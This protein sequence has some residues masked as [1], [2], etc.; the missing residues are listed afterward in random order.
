MSEPP[1]RKARLTELGRESHVTQNA[2]SKLLKQLHDE[3]LPD[4][5]SR[6]AISSDKQRIAFQQT[7]FGASTQ[8]VTVSDK[9]GNPVEIWYQ[10]PFAFLE[11]ACKTSAD[12]K[13][14]FIDSLARSGNKLQ[15]LVYTDEVTPGNPPGDRNSRKLQGIIGASRTPAEQN[16]HS[17]KGVIIN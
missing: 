16:I 10:H 2:L 6:K 7:S 3:D 17:R 11:C 12:F 14:L 5:F 4:A 15:L 9:H 13:Q 1:R 8:K